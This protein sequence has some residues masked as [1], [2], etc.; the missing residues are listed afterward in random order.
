MTP[1]VIPSRQAKNRDH[2]G[3]PLVIPSGQARNRDRPGR[4]RLFARPLAQSLIF[5]LTAL[6]VA[7]A[8]LSAQRANRLPARTGEPT[9]GGLGL[10]R[11][12]R[13]RLADVVRR[14]LN[15]NDTQ[16][17][18]LGQ[19]NDRFERERML[20][21]RDER[22]VRQ[23]LRAEVLAGDSANQT[24]V[25]N[26]L[27][28]A[29]KIQRQRLDVTEREQHDLAGFMTPVQRAR[30]FGIQDELRRRVEDIRQQRQQR[31]AGAPAPGPGAPLP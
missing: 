2:P 9:Q 27:D 5:L 30:Y 12:F 31:R 25:A 22:R 13:E 1:L 23:A 10:E 4:G 11:Q 15:L 17:R 16:M 20:L 26:L 3:I 6:V 21:L 19:V 24:K 18:Q 28:Q 7:S 8:P 14:R 29:L